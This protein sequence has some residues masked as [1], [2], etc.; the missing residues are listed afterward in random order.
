MAH[1]IQPAFGRCQAKGLAAIL[2]SIG[3]YSPFNRGTLRMRLSKLILKAN[4]GPIDITFRGGNFRV[5]D[6]SHPIEFGM[7]L[8]PAY[9]APELDFLTEHLR[10]GSV[11]IDLGA[12]IGMFTIPMAVNAGPNG[13]VIAIDPSKAF[14]DKA[15]FNAAASG[16]SNI[17]FENV[18]VGDADGRVNLQSVE[19]NPGTATVAEAQDGDTVMRPLLAL[20]QDHGVDR[21]DAMKVDIDGF[22]EKALAP[23]FQDCPDDLLPK[24]VVI[25]HILLEEQDVTF[26]DMM[27]QRGYKEVGRTRSNALFSIV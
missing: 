14:Q 13:K 20:V 16:L 5:F 19:G 18:A 4:G 3:R 23:F 11:A 7:M 1:T 10:D 27:L 17:A 21:V 26:I 8:Y 2:L 9:N 6:D 12:N 25:E 24:R 22:E 15:R